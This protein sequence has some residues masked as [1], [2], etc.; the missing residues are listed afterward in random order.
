[1]DLPSG[2]NHATGQFM[3]ACLRC[4]L[5]I[6]LLTMKRG[7]FTYQG[8]DSWKEITFCKL[9][10]TDI[11]SENYLVTANNKLAN[12]SY[13]KSKDYYHCLLYTSDAADE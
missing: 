8:R 7:L 12:D 1:M 11:T 3:P 5:L 4:D 9:I 13:I 6:S 10:N 2:L